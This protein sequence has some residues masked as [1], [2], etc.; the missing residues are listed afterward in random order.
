MF[1][2]TRRFAFRRKIDVGLIHYMLF[3]C[4]GYIIRNW[5][6][7]IIE[8]QLLSSEKGANLRFMLQVTRAN[9]SNGVDLKLKLRNDGKFC[10]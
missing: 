3:F 10:Y 2:Y 4:L 1:I 7:V 8:T 9:D 5:I 6:E